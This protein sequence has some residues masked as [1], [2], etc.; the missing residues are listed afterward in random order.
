MIT[1]QITSKRPDSVMYAKMVG[2]YSFVMF[3][4][5]LMLKYKDI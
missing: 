4:L 1:Q 3:E 2:V 5:T